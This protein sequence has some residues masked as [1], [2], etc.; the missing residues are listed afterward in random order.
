MKNVKRI[1]CVLVIFGLVG[2][3]GPYGAGSIFTDMKA[4]VTSTEL[5]AGSKT[6]EA[7]MVNYLGVYAAGDASIAAAAKNGGITKIKTVDYKFSNILGIIM[8]TT[9]IVTGD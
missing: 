1:L 8:T 5:K 4:P 6:G 3:A 9:T 2:C 7:K